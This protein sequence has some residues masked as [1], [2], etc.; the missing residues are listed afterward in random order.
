MDRGSGRGSSRGS[1]S[2]RRRGRNKGLAI[3]VGAAFSS[4]GRGGHS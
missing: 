1:S 2:D 3:A 4:R